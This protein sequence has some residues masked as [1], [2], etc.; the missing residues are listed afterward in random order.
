MGLFFGNGLTASGGTL[1]R[2]GWCSGPSPWLFRLSLGLGSTL[3]RYLFRDLLAL[4]GLGLPSTI[5]RFRFRGLLALYGL[6]LGSALSRFRFRGLLAVPNFVTV[7]H[8]R[9]LPDIW[10]KT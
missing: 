10:D 3:G 4:Y 6:G 5:S 8:R 1:A 2:P 7:W 9:S